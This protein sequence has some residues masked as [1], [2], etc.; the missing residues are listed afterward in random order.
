MIIV[1]KDQE[2]GMNRAI[3][4]SYSILLS[5]SQA[6]LAAFYYPAYCWLQMLTIKKKNYYALVSASEAV[7]SLDSVKIWICRNQALLLSSWVC[8][9]LY[10]QVLLSAAVAGRPLQRGSDWGTPPAAPQ[11]CHL[12]SACCISKAWLHQCWW[13]SWWGRMFLMCLQLW[14]FLQEG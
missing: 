4:G 2:K 3:G 5:W 6:L 9:P 1:K 14:L 12:D 11:D 7:S 10:R 8:V 13:S